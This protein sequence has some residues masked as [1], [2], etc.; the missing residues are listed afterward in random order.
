MLKRTSGKNVS[1]FTTFAHTALKI[2]F[3]IQET[4]IFATF[5][6]AIYVFLQLSKKNEYTVMKASGVSIWQFLGPF[7]VTTGIL[8]IILLTI[9]NPISSSMLIKQQKIKYKLLSE[10]ST[11]NPTAIFESGFWLIDNNRTENV[12]LIIHSASINI[13]SKETRLN[14]ISALYVD[15]KFHLSKSVDAEYALLKDDYWELYSTTEYV[16]KHRAKQYSTYKIP[17][18]ITRTELQNNFERPKRI[19][20]WELPY[21]IKTLKSTGHSAKI[22]II[23]FYKLLVKPF[24][25]LALLCIAAPFTLK[26]FR[27][28]KLAQ[29]IISCGLIGFTVYTMAEL[30]YLVGTDSG[31]SPLSTSVLFLGLISLIG[32]FTIKHS[33]V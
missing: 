22:H 29:S 21:F 18:T 32:F 28:I 31:L 20:I 2:P 23:Y 13:S 1:L 14:K 27:G 17:T 12:K 8:S 11:K 19:S 4:F 25:A 15:N 7:L 6:A 3:I 16:P 24:I 10:E 5:I 30:V 26:P 9:I 33:K